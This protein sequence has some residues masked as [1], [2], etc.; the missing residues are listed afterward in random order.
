LTAQAAV[1]IPDVVHTGLQVCDRRLESLGVRQQCSTNLT[2]W[3]TRRAIRN[4][5]DVAASRLQLG[6]KL[7][8]CSNQFSKVRISLLPMALS[9]PGS[10]SARSCSP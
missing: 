10:R 3:V 9:P 1:Q 4:I 7:V 5:L 6:R 2:V 8:K